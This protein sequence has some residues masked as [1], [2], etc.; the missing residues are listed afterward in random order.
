MKWKASKLT[1]DSSVMM[2]GMGIRAFSQGLVFIIIA[3]IMGADGYGSFV[4]IIA[5]SGTLSGLVGLGTHVL[6]TRDI[7]F[8]A[9]QFHKA[10]GQTLLSLAISVPVIFLIYILL[11]WLILADVNWSAILLIGIADLIFW[12]LSHICISAYQGFERIGRASRMILIPA[13]T[14]LFAALVFLYL[15]FNSISSA[16]LILNWAILYLCA[17]AIAT[18]YAHWFIYHDIGKPLFSDSFSVNRIKESIPFSFWAIS[19]KL[20]ADADKVMLARMTTMDITGTYSAAYRFI[21]IGL[22]PLYGLIGAATPRFFKEGQKGIKSSIDYSLQLIKFPLMIAICISILI[23]FIADSI[24]FILGKDFTNSIEIIHML[25]FMPIIILPRVFMQSILATINL[26]QTGMKIIFTG[27]LINIV[28]NL[29]M[30][31]IWGWFG[32]VIETYFAE[33][34]MSASM[35]YTL[36]LQLKK[37]N[38]ETHYNIS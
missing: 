1:K 15:T 31:P 3:R 37:Y 22:I 14:R 19:D 33:I 21:D 4:S 28:C 12:P 29:F 36:Y 25:A 20:Y 5:I 2:L 9:K 26:Q 32:A 8:D 13:I 38:K 35:A 17:A 6:L 30:I 16:T 10:W 7:A 18:A 27:S 24:P 23:Y 34:S 11:I